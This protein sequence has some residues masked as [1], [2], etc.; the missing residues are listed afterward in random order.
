MGRKSFQEIGKPLLNRKT[1]VISNTE[2]YRIGRH[3]KR[4]LLK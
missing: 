2:K 4:R 3:E 1:I